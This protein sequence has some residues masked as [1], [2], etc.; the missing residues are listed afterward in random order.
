MS[1]LCKTQLFSRWMVVTALL[2][3]CAAGAATE[4]AQAQ[5]ASEQPFMAGCAA[6]PLVERQDLR[7]LPLRREHGLRRGPRPVRSGQRRDR[8]GHH[9]ERRLHLADQSRRQHAHAEV[10]RRQPQRPDAEPPP[11]QR[12]HQRPAVRGRHQRRALVRHGERRAAR[13]RH[14]RGRA[15]L[16]RHRGR[17][18]RDHLGHADRDRGERHLARV[19]DRTGRR[20]VGRRR[21]SA[22]GPAQRRGLRPGRQHRRGEHRRQR[23]AHVLAPTASSSGPSTRWTAATTDW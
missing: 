19:P 9:S 20:L 2:A 18:G 16:Q 15:T 21:R 12:H 8:P 17:R 10:D 4:E 6:R 1:R 11:R 7:R 14:R 22:A 3:V 13:Q 23:R 5:E